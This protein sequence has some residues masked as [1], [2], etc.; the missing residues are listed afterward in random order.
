MVA[1][2]AADDAGVMTSINEL[3]KQVTRVVA[4]DDPDYDTARAV[5]NGMIDRRPAAVVPAANVDDVIATVNFARDTGAVGRG[6]EGHGAP[7]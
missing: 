6:E 1:A 3:R 7:V 5:W 4:P 2:T